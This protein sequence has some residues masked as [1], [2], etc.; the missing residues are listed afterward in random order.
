MNDDWKLI[1]RLFKALSTSIV[2]Y[3]AEFWILRYLEEIEKIQSNFLKKI[4][5]VPKNTPAYEGRPNMESRNLDFMVFKRILNSI[6]KILNLEEDR[7]P[8]VFL[9]TKTVKKEWYFV[10]I[11]FNFYLFLLS[12]FYFIGTFY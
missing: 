8:T 2:L 1:D 11:F 4:I 5:Q 12:I 10:Y 9:E 3:V 6:E 7:Y